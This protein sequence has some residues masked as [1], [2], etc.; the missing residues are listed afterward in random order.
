MLKRELCRSRNLAVSSPH[1]LKHKS[2]IKWSIVPC[3]PCHFKLLRTCC[4]ISDVLADS[5]D[6][7]IRCNWTNITD[8][9]CFSGTTLRDCYFR[10]LPPNHRSCATTMITI[11]TYFET[12]TASLQTHVW[13]LQYWRRLRL[14]HQERTSRS[15][16]LKMLVEIV[17]VL[18]LRCQSGY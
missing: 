11:M 14:G 15:W 3:L 8:E 18:R 16:C 10:H 9:A 4:Q 7:I 17:L 1:L 2:I 5:N 12:V 13:Y 6:D